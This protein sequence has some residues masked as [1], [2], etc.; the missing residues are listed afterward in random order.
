MKRK[1]SCFIAILSLTV[2]LGC[3]NSSGENPEHPNSCVSETF[4]KECTGLISYQTCIDGV[5]V[6]QACPENY[7]CAQGD[8]T[9]VMLGEK[10]CDAQ[11]YISE[12]RDNGYT[13]CVNGQLQTKS[14]SSDQICQS[15]KCVNSSDPSDKPSDD[16]KTVPTIPETCRDDMMHPYCFGNIRI[17][18]QKDT[19]IQ[20]D[21][22]DFNMACYYGECVAPQNQPCTP[23]S[24]KTQCIGNNVVSCDYESFS[25]QND[26]CGDDVCATV[27][28]VTDCYV[29][30]D[31]SD[32]SENYSN[33]CWGLSE[34]ITG[35]CLE[36]DDHK[37]VIANIQKTED[38][39]S[40][41]SCP[42]EGYCH[43]GECEKS[44]IDIS[45][46]CDNS[47]KQVCDR[48]IA[49]TCKKDRYDGYYISATT[50]GNQTCVIHDNAS[51][52]LTPCD[53]TL[54]GTHRNYCDYDAYEYTVSA[55]SEICQ[56]ISGQYYWIKT[57]QECSN[58]CNE[59]TGKCIE[60]G[61]QCDDTKLCEPSSPE[62]CTTGVDTERYLCKHIQN[63]YQGYGSDRY[64]FYSIKEKCEDGYWKEVDR[65]NCM[66]SYNGCDMNTGKCIKPEATISSTCQAIS[67]FCASEDYV[68]QCLYGSDSIVQVSCSEGKCAQTGDESFDCVVPCTKDDVGS[69]LYSE[70][71]GDKKSNYFECVKNPY[72]IGPE[73]YLVGNTETCKEQ[74]MNGTCSE[75]I[76]PDEGREC[77]DSYKFNCYND[78]SAYCDWDVE[79]RDCRASDEICINT[80]EY[81]GCYE[82]CT[83]EDYHSKTLTCTTYDEKTYSTGRKCLKDD[84][85]T[86]FWSNE[87]EERCFHGCDET[88]GECILIHPQEG[89]TC[90]DAL[91]PSKC[92]GKYRLSCHSQYIANDCEEEL[93]SGATCA[94]LSNDSNQLTPTCIRPCEQTGETKS[95]CKNEN[96][97][98]Q[99][100]CIET[101]G[102]KQWQ[103]DNSVNEKCKHGCDAEI[104]KCIKLSE[105]EGAACTE[106]SPHLCDG[107]IRLYCSNSS[108]A[109]YECTQTHP[110][111]LC[112]LQ[113]GKATCLEPCDPS[114]VNSMRNQC[115]TGSGWN[116]SRLFK[117]VCT[118]F[119]NGYFWKQDDNNYTSCDHGCDA[120]LSQCVK[121]V[122]DEYEPCDANT[123]QQSCTDNI[124]AMCSETRRTVFTKKCSDSEI[125]F[126]S[127]SIN[128][129]CYTKCEPEQV[130]TSSKYCSYSN[131]LET[132]TCT[133]VGSEYIIIT[134]GALCYNGCN[135]DRNDCA[136]S[137]YAAGA[138]CDSLQ[139]DKCA[140]ETHYY[141]C[142]D[143]VIALSECADGTKCH[144]YSWKN[145]ECLVPECEPGHIEYECYS[146]NQVSSVCS[147]QKDGSYRHSGTTTIK[148]DNGCNASTGMCY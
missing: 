29:P 24:F 70:C 143:N 67:N 99:D 14:C 114:Q 53:S 107:A 22:S 1:A 117:A 85:G 76:H 130:G 56:E 13:I 45:D 38:G 118:E 133:Q 5:L 10:I 23:T 16:D 131:R 83:E 112:A 146:N 102:V 96:Y 17:S 18:C 65:E 4:Q 44:S 115:G 71:D 12:C 147:Q 36:S 8:C 138:S 9:P 25:L 73:Y 111:F 63:S 20:T 66:Y 122:S 89:Q 64:P 136:P 28:G 104:G 81:K 43:Q 124:L 135:S 141:T 51:K 60:S 55:V 125:C 80:Q 78:V 31:F 15:G 94:M 35:Q 123:Y 54:K 19:V 33:Y 105:N 49:Y 86:Y 47:F 39:S 142:I 126:S 132:S 109:I 101:D 113:D 68:I 90:G 58:A 129:A 57:V 11:D 75:N 30:C 48:N 127:E 41:L 26:L 40:Y 77:S 21:C 34:Y 93:G 140:D 110:N 88:T 120:A 3:Q 145:A 100:I 6:T 95:K 98:T 144:N 119:E 84:N 7:I 42:D 116:S 121:I 79:V 27:N 62:K 108:Y 92:D 50:C 2:I 97:E 59:Y 82:S 128:A 61:K 69:I 74:C 87:I 37:Y 91:N 46:E 137:P 32:I 72:E 139:Y 106:D 103:T 148:C 134:T 52:C